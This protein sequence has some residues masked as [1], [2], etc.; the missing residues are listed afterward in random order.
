MNWLVY[1]LECNDKTYYCGVTNNL[2]Q[3][4]IKHNQ[5]KGAKYTRARLP[6]KLLD[7][8]EGLTK[9]EAL[10]LEYRIK[11]M[12]RENKLKFFKEYKNVQ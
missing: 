8:I 6:V 4:I 7:K 5:G 10:K 11:Q 3:R 2:E 9:S 1:L 12:K